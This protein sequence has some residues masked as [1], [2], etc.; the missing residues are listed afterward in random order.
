[1]GLRSE[2]K[3]HELTYLPLRLLFFVDYVRRTSGI[4]ASLE[5]IKGNVM[6]R[7]KMSDIGDVS[8]VLGVQ[9]NHGFR[10]GSLVTI[11]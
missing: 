7:S 4:K 9:V 8:R 2:A 10:L 1:M 5:L 3:P 11:Q 6:S